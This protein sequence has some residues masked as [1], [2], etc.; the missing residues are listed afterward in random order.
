MGRV[1]R[2]AEAPL[3]EVCHC[4]KWNTRGSMMKPVTSIVAFVFLLI[5]LM[6]VLRLVLDWQVTVGTMVIPKWT[7][8]IA[9]LVSL[10]LTLGLIREGRAK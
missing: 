8:I 10:A 1:L 7:S 2:R 6:H 9:I 3:L 4:S 5:A